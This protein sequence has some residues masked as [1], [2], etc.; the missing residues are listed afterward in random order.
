MLHEIN[1]HDWA[2]FCRRISRERHGAAIQ[3]KTVLADGSQSRQGGDLMLHSMD[4]DTTNPCSDVIHLRAE[5]K[6]DA[7]HDIVEPIHIL[8][9]DSQPGEDFNQVQIQSE[10]GTTF[11]TFRPPIHK[12]MLEG[13]KVT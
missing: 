9:H 4:F 8:L 7:E 13:L 11:L 5:N 10:S 6:S 12:D 2:E 3:V 1:N